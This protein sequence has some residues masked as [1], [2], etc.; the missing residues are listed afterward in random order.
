MDDTISRQAAIDTPE[1]FIKDCNPEHFVAHQK[2]IEFMDNAEIGSFGNWQFAN[3]FN[4][5]LTAAEVA[6]KQ[7]PSTQPEITEEAVDLYCRQRCLIVITNELYNEMKTRWSA[8]PEPKKGKW[9]LDEDP[10]DGDCRCSA[11]HIAI[12]QMHERNHGLL[13]ALTGGKWWTF[14]NFCPNCGADMRGEEDE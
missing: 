1:K 11:C 10:H 9:I 3:G 7:L 4:M 14:Y 5:G 2:F 6:I 13:N 8:E 12:D